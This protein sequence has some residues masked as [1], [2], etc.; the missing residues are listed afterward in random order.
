[1]AELVFTDAEVSFGASMSLDLSDHVKSVKIDYK[2]EI[3]DLT[4]MGDSARSRYPGLT[5][6][7]MTI[8]FFQDYAAANVDVTMFG[9]IGSTSGI[10][11]SV[12]P[13][14]GTATS[15][16]NPRY[17]GLF[18]LESYSPVDAN[19]G[20]LGTVSCNFVGSG[21]LTRASADA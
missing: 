2:A 3:H 17:H 18:F 6:A 8:E 9:Y 19:V 4:E 5:D 13:V 1:M 7:N 12:V 21:G 10:T 15:A 16:T 14:K 11:I 20:E